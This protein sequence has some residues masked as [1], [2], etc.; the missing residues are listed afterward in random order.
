MTRGPQDGRPLVSTIIPTFNRRDVVRRAIASALAQTYSNQE[1][2]VVDDGS[3]DDTKTVLEAEYG[4]RIRYVHQ[5]NSGVSA[6]RNK[7]M[8]LAQGDFIALLDSDDQWCV[9]KI[10]KQ[11]TFLLSHPDFGM[12]VT[13]V[14]RVNPDG[15][16]IDIFRRR[17]V[18]P[19][20]G[21]V[22]EYVVLNPSL[23]PASILIRR[24]VVDRLGGFDES[25]R[26]AEDIE[27]HLRIAERY[28]IGV[29][30]EP[31]TIAERG[32]VGLSG[33]ASSDTDY[34][35]VVEVFLNRMR[36]RLS[37]AK[38]RKALFTTYTRNSISAFRSRRLRGGVGFWIR[39]LANVSSLHDFVELGK[40]LPLGM[41]A[42]AVQLRRMVG[43]IFTAR[44]MH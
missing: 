20:D 31:L 42:C 25:L 6:A 41:R 7:G 8:R 9:D 27:F 30:E 26:T 5:A 11:V 39:A 37:S 16:E 2:I 18:Q 35:R 15:C 17:E 22:L 14:R 34:V 38:R 44:R 12:A 33:E 3:T 19:V 28:R 4:D 40:T 36:R 10:Q 23:V 29:I 32:G 43:R 1:I 24:E 13:D 21:D